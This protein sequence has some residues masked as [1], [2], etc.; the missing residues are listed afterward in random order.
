[1]KTVDPV[2]HQIRR[3]GIVQ[4]ALHL[5]A[6]AGFA[7]TSMDDIAHACKLQKASLYHYFPSKQQLLQELVD[8]GCARWAERAKDF[9][10]EPTLQEALTKIAFTILA[11]MDDPSRREFFKLINYE[12]HKNPCIF[13]ALKESQVR[14]PRV[15]YDIFAK[16]LEG[17][18]TRIEIAMLVTQFMGGIVHYAS[19]AK[20]RGENM[21]L[22]SFDEAS[23]VKHLVHL[24]V[25][26]TRA[27]NQ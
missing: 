5:F 13:K 20:L 1:M 15:V 25:K 8:W 4:H 11:D 21:C 19:M 23:Y 24:F 12:S 17:R 18:F 6:T 2:S 16:F 22:E 27:G 14:N 9:A 10:A 26:G 3:E 7:E